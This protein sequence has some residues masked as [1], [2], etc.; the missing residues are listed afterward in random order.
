MKEMFYQLAQLTKDQVTIPKP[1]LTE[2]TIRSAFTMTLGAAGAIAM[3]IIAIAGF[4]YVVSMGNP[5]QA[6]KA[7]NAIIYALIGLL[8]CLVSFGIVNLVLDEL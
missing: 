8:V 7:K 3:L 1:E 6:A 5:E 4:K 2:N